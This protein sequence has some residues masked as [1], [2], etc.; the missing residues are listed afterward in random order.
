MKIKGYKIVIFLLLLFAAL[1]EVYCDQGE[2]K[3]VGIS[4]E[5]SVFLAIANSPSLKIS[6][7]DFKIRNKAFFYDIA[8]FLPN[9]TMGFSNDNLVAQGKP[10]RRNSELSLGAD[11]LVFDGGKIIINYVERKFELEF[12]KRELLSL[13][14]TIIHD[15][16]RQ[17]FAL[18]VLGE[19]EE[20]M[21]Q[22]LE[23]ALAQQKIAEF[24]Y[25]NGMISQ[26]DYY[27]IQLRVNQIKVDTRQVRLD[28]ENSLIEFQRHIGMDNAEIILESD[29]EYRFL[30]LYRDDISYLQTVAEGNRIDLAQ[31]TYSV[32]RSRVGL[33]NNVLSFLPEVRAGVE[34]TLS[35][36]TFPPRDKG[37]SFYVDVKIPLAYVP[38]KGRSKIAG[39]SVNSEES[40]GTNTSV[41]PGKNIT[42]ENDIAQ[43][44]LEVVKQTI[45]H[46]EMLI[47]MRMEIKKLVEQYVETKKMYELKRMQNDYGEKK[48][49][50]MRFKLETGDVNRAALLSEEQ[51]YRNG[52]ISEKTMLGELI[53][54]ES[55]LQEKLGVNAVNI[56]DLLEKRNSTFTIN[57]TSKHTSGTRESDRQAGTDESRTEKAKEGAKEGAKE[58]ERV[59]EEENEKKE[60]D[61]TDLEIKNLIDE[62]SAE[63]EKEDELDFGI[64]ESGPIF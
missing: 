19:K 59:S 22:I 62:N 41:T 16:R 23:I 36:E 3:A 4:L 49:E 5:K 61:Q 20:L 64:I 43:A 11:C 54:I 25:E 10:D 38:V 24:E 40:N 12:S 14:Q 1:F 58:E 32:Y 33:V 35:D 2:E 28:K 15:T 45:N 7:A 9:L 21:N 44:R 13:T 18:L 63:E 56:H 31:S 8:R 39:K 27:D 53:S 37:W 42:Y 46:H 17:F 34:F 26:L 30:D 50:I 48:L 55:R 6:R 52:L 47:T 29:F 57:L 60:Q 51:S